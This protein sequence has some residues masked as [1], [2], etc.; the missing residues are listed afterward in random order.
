MD[1]QIPLAAAEVRI[2]VTAAQHLEAHQRKAE[3]Q[4]ESEQQSTAQVRLL[5]Q[6]GASVCSFHFSLFFSIARIVS[7]GAK[8]SVMTLPVG[9]VSTRRSAASYVRS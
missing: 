5:H 7:T 3:D 2:E 8:S 9:R 6:R 4:G 1:R